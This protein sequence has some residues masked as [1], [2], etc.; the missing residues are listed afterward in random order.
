M[1]RRDTEK[2]FVTAFWKLYAVKPIEKISINQLCQSAG[3][4]RATFYNHFENIYALLDKAV[5]SIFIPVKEK[6]L[7]KYDIRSLLQGDIIE[8]TLLTYFSSNNIYIELLFKRQNYYL[9]SE[10]IKK[11]LFYKIK[12]EFNDNSINFDMIK[13]L[14]EY[15]ISAILGVISYWYQQGKS[16][17]EQDILKKIYSISSKGVLNSLRDE[18]SSGQK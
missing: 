2:D 1:E 7:S 5:D 15:Q 10:K 8:T 13:I 16:I 4:N 18:I 12:N 6:V 3:Y 17:S 11:E 14:L 9:L